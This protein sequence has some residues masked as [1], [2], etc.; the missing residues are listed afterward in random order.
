MICFHPIKIPIQSIFSL[1]IDSYIPTISFFFTRLMEKFGVIGYH[2]LNLRQHIYRKVHA[3]WQPSL[4]V[5]VTKTKLKCEKKSLQK[6]YKSKIKVQKYKQA[7]MQISKM[8][9]Y[10]PLPNIQPKAGVRY[11]LAAQL[12]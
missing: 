8:Q 3:C 4:I 1:I 11:V 7:N 12:Y 9:K 2:L 5:T 6:N 10:P